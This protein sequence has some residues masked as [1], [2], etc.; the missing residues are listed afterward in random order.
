MLIWKSNFS[1][2]TASSATALYC[3]YSS[4]R[5][6][7]APSVEDKQRW[8]EKEEEEKLEEEEE[9]EEK[10]EEE[11]EKLEEKKEE[12]DDKIGQKSRIKH[13][14]KAPQI[15]QRKHNNKILQLQTRER[16]PIDGMY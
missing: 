1:S 9:K 8:T 4:P 3:L 14:E 13:L 7:P 10:E 15:C 12:K 6:L 5:G 11:E 2:Q 16:G